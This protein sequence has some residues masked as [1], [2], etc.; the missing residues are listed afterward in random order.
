MGTCIE[1]VWDG[2]SGGKIWFAAGKDLGAWPPES[3]Q[4]AA[5][6][7]MHVGNTSFKPTDVRAKLGKCHGGSAAT[8]WWDFGPGTYDMLAHNCNTFSYQALKWMGLAEES[9]LAGFM[10]EN[11]QLNPIKGRLAAWLFGAE[12][13]GNVKQ[14]AW[15]SK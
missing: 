15:V 3:S 5:A 2:R 14:P 9:V 10:P 7:L 8:L 13:I 1:V 6:Q 12:S 4:K 11:R